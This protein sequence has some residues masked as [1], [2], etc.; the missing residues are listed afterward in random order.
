MQQKKE[1]LLKDFKK[2]LENLGVS[3]NTLKNYLSDISHFLRWL[4]KIPTQSGF[5]FVSYLEVLKSLNNNA[6]NEYKRY[7][8]ETQML[9]NSVNRRLSSLR[10][11]SKYLM[12]SQ[13]MTSNITQGLGNIHTDQ[14]NEKTPFL[15]DYRKHLISK[16]ASK[17]TVKNYISDVRHFLTWINTQG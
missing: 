6:G 9:T 11:F 7:L 1:N 5:V 16:G 12:I 4:E 8:L 13:V 10:Q 15:S 17:N 2:Y 14:S 3:K